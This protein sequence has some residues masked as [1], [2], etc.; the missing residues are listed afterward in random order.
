MATS[1]T[2]E[3]SNTVIYAAWLN[4]VND[5][6][7]DGTI[8]TDG[9]VTCGGANRVMMSSSTS[10]YTWSTLAAIMTQAVSG[11]GLVS[12]SAGTLVGRTLTGTADRITVTDGTGVSGNPTIDVASTYTG[13]ATITTLGTIGTGTWSG[14]TIAL[15]KGGTNS[16]SYTTNGVVYNNGTSLVAGAGLTFDGTKLAVG[17][18]G[19]MTVTGLS[20][21]SHLNINKDASPIFSLQGYGTS[22]TPTIYSARARGTQ[23]SP[24]VVSSGD[25]LSV[26]PAVGYDGTDYAVGGYTSFTVAATPGAGDMP[27]NYSVW[28]SADGSETPTKRFELT[29][30]GNCLLPTVTTGIWNA[31]AITSLYGGTGNQY[32]KFSGATSSEKTYTLPDATCSILTS[33]T[34]VTVPQG[35]TGLT[36][37]TTAYG[38]VCAGTTATGTLQNAGAGTAGQVLTSN[39]ASALPTFQAASGSTITDTTAIA[40]DDGDTSKKWA[41]QCSGITASTTRTW[42]IPNCDVPHQ[43]IQVQYSMTSA[44]ATGTTTIPKDD[45]IPQ[46]TEGVEYMT[47]TIT[48]KSTTNI[49][50]ITAAIVGAHSAASNIIAAL[51]QDATANAL[52]VAWGRNVGGSEG[53]PVLLSYI[54][55]AGTTSATTFRIRVGGDAAGTFSFNGQGGARLFNTASK[56][57]LIVEELT[58]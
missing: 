17:T 4:A 50:R 40:Q 58:G 10:A 13:Q 52:A 45:T 12:N 23:A 54:M 5:F 25:N 32:T 44:V 11:N 33:N 56:S 34:P 51:F 2:F 21:L 38:V 26:C 55:T 49:L 20:V 14:T 19:T 28:V 37:L 6:L 43:H 39:G 42:T 57:S 15:N 7:H 3:D 8:P 31:T 46:I 36:T 24:T 48:P 27:T 41:V 22:A 53:Q 16:T 35:G 29:Y 1:T 9:T 47:V 18:A 30:D